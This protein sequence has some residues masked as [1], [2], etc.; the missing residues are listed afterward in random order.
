MRILLTALALFAAPTFAM[1]ECAS[2][3]QAMT[4][5][6]GSAY[7]SASRTCVPVSS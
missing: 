4:C 2:D 7:D 3:K 6:E 1:A 5:A